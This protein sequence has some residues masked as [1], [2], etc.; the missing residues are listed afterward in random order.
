[1]LG[2]SFSIAG[3]NIIIN[4]IVAEI[5][6]QFADSLEKSNDFKNDLAF[7]V[8][9]TYS[10]HK[11][12]IFNGNNYGDEWIKEAEKRGLSNLKTTVDALPVYISQ[13]SIDLF[14]QHNV[15]TEQELHS[16]YEIL[17]EAY[18]KITHIE[19]LTMEDMVKRM[20]IPACVNYQ[21]ELVDLLRQKNA[22]GTLDI[23]MED[24]LLRN[25]SRLSSSLYKALNVLE[26]SIG[27]SKDKK[28]IQSQAKFYRDSVFAAMSE[29]RLIVDEL[30]T[31]IPG[32][33]WS[34]PVY[35]EILFSII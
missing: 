26:K 3:P 27:D 13:K 6:R 35:A 21:R 30:E 15:F 8:S 24:S 7:L 12:I 16:R 32:K 34:L 23:S 11:R 14:S 5:L 10:E 4:T 19:A 31:L 28:D 18:C 17:K 22:Y 20:I 9:K 2:S 33:H 29:L 25:I 1:M